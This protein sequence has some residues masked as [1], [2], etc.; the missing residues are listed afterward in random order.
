VCVC[1]GGGGKNYWI[2]IARHSHE[3]LEEGQRKDFR[4][5]VRRDFK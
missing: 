1:V 5:D 3:E 2:K 4:K